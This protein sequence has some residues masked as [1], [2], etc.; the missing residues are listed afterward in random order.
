MTF[1]APHIECR[2]G[3]AHM[4][5]EK[6]RLLY[7]EYTDLARRENARLEPGENRSLRIYL[8]EAQLR[9]LGVEAHYRPGKRDTAWAKRVLELETFVGTQKRLPRENNRQPGAVPPQEMMLVHWIR[10]QRKAYTEGRLCDYQVRRLECVPGF[11]WAPLTEA[12][13]DRLAA[14]EQFITLN[15]R[16]P[17]LRSTDP[18]ESTLAAWAAKQRFAR[19]NGRLNEERTNALSN[20]PFWTWG[21][22]SESQDRNGS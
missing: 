21:N 4:Q 14:Y 8:A 20:L 11:S 16:A 22:R 7:E 18:A 17:A 12:W 2:G 19:R 6:L 13:E 9:T 15:H 1:L 5:A 3:K 10:N